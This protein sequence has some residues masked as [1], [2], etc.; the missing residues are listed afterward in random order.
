MV[1]ETAGDDRAP[2][3]GPQET[4]ARE[5]RRPR[6][7]YLSFFFPPSRASG[8]FRGRATANHLAES[9]WDVTVLTAPTEFFSYYLDGASDE[10]L[11][12]TV[13]PRVRVVR[14]PMSAYRWE[15]DVRRFGRFGAISRWSGR[16]STSSARNRS[17]RSSTRAGCRACCVGRPRCTCA[18]AST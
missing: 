3:A 6:L 13:D 12:A 5:G 1:D 16:G 14:P 10:T 7:L 15:S 18:G 4:A 17:S 9:G 8:V 2:T 11:L